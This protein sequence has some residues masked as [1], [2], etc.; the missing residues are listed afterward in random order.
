MP[1]SDC[2]Y[3]KT[4]K[5]ASSWRGIVAKRST[6]QKMRREATSHYRIKISKNLYLYAKSSHHFEERYINDGW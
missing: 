1:A 6:K 2:T 5:R 4:Q 3:W